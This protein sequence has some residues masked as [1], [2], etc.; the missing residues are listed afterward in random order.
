MARTAIMMMLLGAAAFG[1]DKIIYQESFDDASSGS[2]A[3]LGWRVASSPDRSTYTVKDGM[4]HVRITPN[5]YRD[6]YAEIDLPLCRKG[7]IDLD[8]LIDPE[9]LNLQAIGLTL[10]LYNI[11]TFWHDTCKDWRAYFPQPTANRMEGF[12]LEPVGHQSIGRVEKH[13]WIHY[14]IC[15]DTD[16]DRVEFY[17]DN[18][19]DPAYIKADAP[20]LGR[21]E[22]QGGKLRIGSFG[23]APRP[24]YALVDNIV[25]RDLTGDKEELQTP[26]RDTHLLFR[27]MSFELYDIGGALKAAGVEGSALRNYDLDFWRQSIVAENTF[28]YKSFPGASSLSRAKSIVLIDAPFGPGEIMPEFL[29]RD[30]ISSVRDGARLVVLGGLFSLGKGEYQGT[31]LERVLPV[32]L[33]DAWDVKGSS[34]P[35]EIAA[36]CETLQDLNWSDRPCVYYRHDLEITDDA[37]VLLEAD[38]KPL[39]VSRKLG[40]GEIVVFLG[41]TCGPASTNP[42]AFWRWKDWPRLVQ[43][44]LSQGPI[45]N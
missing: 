37:V 8:V 17:I 40:Q 6:G 41:A 27:G 4:L 15:F 31:L 11:S 23:Y 43:R 12:R 28:K 42:P 38:G 34:R 18:M 20:V 26:K 39:L 2:L 45:T 36:V 7:Q 32:K 24:Y 25:V 5:T 21:D 19:Q 9:R 1:Q 10:D 30:F 33:A 44:I 16:N 13:K 14:R 22:Y 35:V 3:D 29:Q